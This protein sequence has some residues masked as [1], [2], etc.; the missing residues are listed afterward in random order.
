MFCSRVEVNKR[1]QILTVDKNHKVRENDS[2]Q[3]SERLFRTSKPPQM[4]IPT[5]T[6]PKVA[7]SGM[8]I[9]ELV[10]SEEFSAVASVLSPGFTR[11]A[12]ALVDVQAHT[13]KAMANI[14][15]IARRV[16][17]IRARRFGTSDYWP[18]ELAE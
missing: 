2:V 14:T 5:D 9:R 18:D 4:A 15:E 6:I 1:F 10:T 3:T 16:M 7:G 13:P 17:V 8:A 11:S 12:K